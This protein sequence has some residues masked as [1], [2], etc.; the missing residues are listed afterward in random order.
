[1]PTYP[2]VPEPLTLSLKTPAGDDDRP[3]FVAGNFNNW[4]AGDPKFEMRRTEDGWFQFRFPRDF[5]FQLPVE[6]KYLRGDWSGAEIDRFGN[7]TPNR[8]LR[9]AR[10]DQQDYVPRWRH[11]GQNYRHD[12]LPQVEVISD[13]FELPAGVRTRRV[14]A[15][16]PHD[17]YQNERRYPVL[18]LQDGQ[19][20]FD[21]HAPFGNWDLLRQLAG[22]Q[23]IG[24]GNFI[25]IAI[26]HAESDR[27]EEYTP[28]F[29]TKL[30]VG[31]GKKYV[32]YLRNVVK[33]FVDKHFRTMP[34]REFTGIGGSSMGGLISIY[35]GLMYPETYSKMLIFSPSLWVAPNIHRFKSNTFG[36]QPTKVYLYAGGQE[37]K[38]LVNR[39]KRFQR[40]IERACG[41]N[42]ELSIKLNVNPNGQHT[43]HEWG[44]EFP[45]AAEWLFYQ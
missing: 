10:L 41:D 22:L 17:Y 38:T 9:D 19:N 8:I 7:E 34:G 36:A 29:N 40:S 21:E 15:L 6:Y 16:L 12:L 30:G 37:S 11:N 43:E 3:V 33:P 20:L 25:V 24:R 14:A 13:N 26:D 39:V 27:I 2:D 35:A 42:N 18:Y 31:T 4:T 44:K 1:M 32:R 28:S 45:R 5:S 23:S